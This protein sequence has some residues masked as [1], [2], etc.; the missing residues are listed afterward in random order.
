MTEPVVLLVDNG[1][2]RAQATLNLRRIAEQITEA[3][4]RTVHPV[5]LQHADRVSA[6]ALD[7]RAANILTPFLREQL[8][9][10]QRQFVILPLFFGVSRAL[11]SFIP[12]QVALLREA[13]GDFHVEV[14]DVLCPLPQGEPMLVDV[15]ADNVRRAMSHP[16][17]VVVVDHGSPIPEVTAVR[18]WLASALADRF[19]SGVVVSEAVMERRE[20]SSYDF[21]GQLLEDVLQDLSGKVVLSMLFV[22]PGR[23]AGEG[24]DIAEICLA[25]ESANQD[26]TVTASPLVG[27]HPRLIAVLSQRLADAIANWSAVA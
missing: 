17:R 2:R 16:Q 11:T 8:A 23:H 24:G 22:S 1:S 9:T 4:G 18:R 26:L 3:T 15:L 27:E 19:E 21:N 25:A 5:S 13:F 10:G 7:G 6:E 14:A 12:E 20:G